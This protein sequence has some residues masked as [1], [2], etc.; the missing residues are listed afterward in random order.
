MLA[1]VSRGAQESVASSS[2]GSAAASIT[3][4]FGWA[5]EL[6][7]VIG[8]FSG[9][10]RVYLLFVRRDWKRSSS[11]FFKAGTGEEHAFYRAG[12]CGGSYRV[13]WGGLEGLG[14][15]CCCLLRLLLQPATNC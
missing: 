11:V 13:S 5:S 15:R 4:C 14:G 7:V 9:A 6:V 1:G 10:R 2:M 8:P 12:V 3:A